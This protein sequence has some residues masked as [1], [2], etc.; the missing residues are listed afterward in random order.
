MQDLRDGLVP[1]AF[2]A[3]VARD[4]LTYVRRAAFPAVELTLDDLVAFGDVALAAREPHGCAAVLR[5]EPDMLMQLVGGRGQG[6]IKVAGNDRAAVDGV[7]EDVVAA[8]REQEAGDEVPVTFWAHSLGRPVNPRRRI[9]APRWSEICGNYGRA[10]REG[11]DVLMAADGPGPGGLLLWHGAPGTGKSYAL[12]ALARE[13]RGWC[14]THFITDAEAFLG[15][16][17]Y[18]LDAL[19]R[20]ERDEAGA[21]GR[22][23]RLV[24][25]EDSG[26]LLAA[27]ARALAGQALSRLLNLSDGLLGEGLRVIV[28]VTT[29]EPLRRLHPA[30][31]RPGRTWMEIEFG[32]LSVEE[33]NTWL[34]ARARERRVQRATALAELFAD[35]AARRV[36]QRAGLG[37]AR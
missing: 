18:L 5:L 2:N 15:T 26:E 9:R 24:V 32:A 30:V 31:V 29:N 37:F 12:R 8:L 6:T 11:L 17:S 36:P 1:A 23:W 16:T 7:L 13:W 33:A 20:S 19:M 35:D 27:D 28:L 21:S 25:L 22:R 4:G 34:D 3:W 10:T 14:D